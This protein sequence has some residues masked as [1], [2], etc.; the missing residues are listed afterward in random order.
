MAHTGEELILRLIE[1]IDLLPL[2]LASSALRP[3]NPKGEFK[4][5][6]DHNAYDN[7]RHQR[8]LVAGSK[9]VRGQKL[10]EPIGEIITG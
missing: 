9:R 5:Q 3:V 7:H 8:I 2:L 4:H 1:L 10:R 6:T